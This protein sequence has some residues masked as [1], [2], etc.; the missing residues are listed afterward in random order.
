MVIFGV[1]QSLGVEARVRPVLDTSDDYHAS[2]EEDD[3]L[4]RVGHNL[5][6]IELVEGYENEP[7]SETYAQ[8]NHDYQ[9][10]NWLNE[11]V[12]SNKASQLAYTVVSYGIAQSFSL[13]T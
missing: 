12:D 13:L 6:E 5:S 7:L 2:D 10:I 8:W 1:L 3:D 11:P 9:Q 4:D